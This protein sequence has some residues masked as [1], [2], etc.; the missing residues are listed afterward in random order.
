MTSA[1]FVSEWLMPE[2]SNAQIFKA[3]LTNKDSFETDLYGNVN[4][5][6]EH[7]L[8]LLAF[9]Y[10]GLSLFYRHLGTVFNVSDSLWLV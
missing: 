2:Y 4:V 9:E 5:I 1:N 6:D 3:S 10:S 8:L 7:H